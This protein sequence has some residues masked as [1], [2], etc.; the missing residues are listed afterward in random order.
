MKTLLYFIAGVLL[1]TGCQEKY[2]FD[3]DFTTPTQLESPSSIK[4]DVTS[5]ETVTLSW[6]GGCAADG[7][8]VLYQIL[9]DKKDG[10]FSSPIETQKSDLGAEPQ[11]TLTQSAL[12]AICRKAGIY[13]EETGDIKWTVTA[14]KGG[15]VKQSDQV[16]TI[17]VTRGEGIDNIPEK[18][19]LTGSA[20]RESE[21]QFR[22]ISEGVFRIYT[23]LG[24][25]NIAFRSSDK[26]DAFKYYVDERPKLREGEGNT[27]V[28]ASVE[29]SRITVDFNTLSMKVEEIGKSVRCIWG[30]TF[31][32]IATLNYIGNG[33]FQGNGDIIFVDQSR[34]S[35][36]PPS[37]LS[38]TE[39]RYYFIAKVNG[40]DT[41]W[42]K[43]D[44]IS[45]ERPTGGETS[46]FYELHEFAWSQWDHLWKMS[47]SLDYTHATVT[48]N[49]N[50]DNLM[51]HSFT[52]VSSIK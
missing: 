28:S 36:N 6:T 33:V 39:E 40:T 47:G 2:Y 31:G 17:S 42:G 21:N 11:L 4:L 8:I 19:Y 27:P 48:I 34:P 7:G 22:C 14:S 38:W 44:G 15:I 9:F 1:I 41:C 16:A 46:S 43:G 25:G 24:N 18:L 13:P 23:L 20:T 12:N 52:N 29:L 30:C 26:E 50:S 10:D 51:I 32:D 3:P 35:T 49:T 37:W 5:S 45:G